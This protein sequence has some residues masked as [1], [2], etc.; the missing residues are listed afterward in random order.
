MPSPNGK[1]PQFQS[2]MREEDRSRDFD[3]NSGPYG[4]PLHYRTVEDEDEFGKFQRMEEVDGQRLQ[5]GGLSDSPDDRPEGAPGN[6]RAV[7]YP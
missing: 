6:R 2:M 1:A 7:T 3:V 5:S 4:M